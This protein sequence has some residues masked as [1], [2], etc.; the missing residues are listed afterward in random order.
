[1]GRVF[2]LIFRW[3][4]IYYCIRV[5]NFSAYSIY[6]DGQTQKTCIAALYNWDNNIIINVTE[7]NIFFLNIIF[8]PPTKVTSDNYYYQ[9]LHRVQ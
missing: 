4:D 2:F 6:I 5:R 3:Y 8:P 7:E 9:W 1:M